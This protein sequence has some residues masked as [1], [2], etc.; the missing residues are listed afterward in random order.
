MQ[1]TNPVWSV[2]DVFTNVGTE[3]SYSQEI[4]RPYGFDSLMTYSS[5]EQDEATTLV[6]LSPYSSKPN[7]VF[8]FGAARPL[9]PGARNNFRT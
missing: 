5:Y 1:C 4:A 9:G 3:L 8:K 7:A 2:V 6:I